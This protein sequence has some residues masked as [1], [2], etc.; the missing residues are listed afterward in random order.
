MWAI[1]TIHNTI[2]STYLLSDSVEYLSITLMKLY[3]EP[4]LYV[5]FPL[6]VFCH[7]EV[8]LTGYEAS[9]KISFFHVCIVTHGA[10]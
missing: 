8:S 5:W 10:T 9:K 6:V 7:S 4:R 1:V 3:V 2:L